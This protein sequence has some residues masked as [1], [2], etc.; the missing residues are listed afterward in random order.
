MCV[1]ILA[2]SI[3]M[4]LSPFTLFG[5]AHPLE[6]GYGQK[7][8][9]IF[10]VDEER[11]IRVLEV[12]PVLNP[13]KPV[14]YNR[15][16]FHPQLE[17]EFVSKYEQDFGKYSVERSYDIETSYVEGASSYGVRYLEQEQVTAQKIYGEFVVKRLAEHHVDEFTKTSP[18]LRPMYELKE[19]ISKVNLEV[20]KGYKVNIHYSLS[21]NFLRLNITN[22]YDIATSVI[23]QMD[24][25][26]FGPSDI[27]NESLNLGYQINK[28]M[29]VDSHIGVENRYYSLS[30]SKKVSKVFT[31]SVTTSTSN[32]DPTTEAD[33]RILFGFAWT[34]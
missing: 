24:P 33:N 1:K 13:D 30:G 4:V 25:N 26:K 7:I 20:K 34:Y 3:F 6:S 15:L 17:R 29:R 8:G 5:A 2:I 32:P 11:Y 18:T 22:P 21:G 27:Q 14:N 28:K 12:T 31:T 16:I 19:K 10:D 23:L 9:Y